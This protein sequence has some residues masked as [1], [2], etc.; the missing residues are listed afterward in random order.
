MKPLAE[1]LVSTTGQ[2]SQGRT[3]TTQ[4]VVQAANPL[5]AAQLFHSLLCEP[6]GL[7]VQLWEDDG[8]TANDE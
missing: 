8:E 7:S 5:D 6:V 4:M 2:T 3:V 1:Y